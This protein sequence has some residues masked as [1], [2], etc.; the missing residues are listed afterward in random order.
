MAEAAKVRL[1]RCPKCENLLQELPDFSLYQCGGCGAVLKATQKGILEDGLTEISDTVKARGVSEEDRTFKVSEV[2]MESDDNNIEGR[3][4]EKAR[5]EG[6]V[7]NGSSTSRAESTEA[8]R[9]DSDTTRR[10]KERIRKLESFDN[11][12]ASY[13][14]GPSRNRNQ[15]SNL[16]V[17]GPEYVK[18]IRPPPMMDPLRSKP[19]L[20]QKWGMKMNEPTFGPVRGVPAQMRFDDYRYYDE[21]QSSYETS[22]YY[23]PGEKASRYRGHNMDGISQTDNID[24]GR[25][26]LI[27]RLDELKDQI[28]RSCDISDKSKERIISPDPYG[29]RQ[30]PDDVGPTYFA[31]PHVYIPYTD[32][33]IPHGPDP[34]PMRRHPPEF[35][36][37][38]NNNNNNAYKPEIPRR[39]P[40]GPQPQYAQHHPYHEPFPGHYGADVNHH[41]LFTL[42]RHENFF[43]QPAC[44]C[45]YCCDKNWH[46]PLPKP[47]NPS[48]GLHNR[49]FGPQKSLSLNSN[50][51]D[52]EI[53]G[54][55]H[56]RPRKLVVAHR[57][58]RVSHP[59]A[60]GAPFV[61]CS[62]CYEILKLPKKC[63]MSGESQQKLK[64]GACSSIIMFEL[65]NKGFIAS[66]SAHVVDQVPSE[67]DEGSSGT[68]DENMR[69]WNDGLN[70]A[71]LNNFSND[72]EDFVHKKS[73]SDILSSASNISEDE[74]SPKN[75]L[76]GPNEVKPFP[77][78]NL[79]PENI[80][81]SCFDKGNKS[82]RPEQERAS[83]DR[84]TSSQ[85]R[86]VKDA[87]EMD[88]SLNEFSNSCAS[89]DSVEVSKEA[90]K[91]KSS[92][93]GSGESFF[94]GLI[95]RSFI[96]DL[97]KS[98]PG[99]VE[100]GGGS[101]VFINGHFIPD[102]VVK[103]AEKSAGPIKPGDYWYDKRAGFWGVMG[104]PCLGIIM[105]NIEEFNYP[106]PEK[107]AAGNTGVCVNGRELHQKD[108]D[109]L[110]SRGLPIT[111]HRSY[112]VEITGKVIDEQTGQELDGLGKLAPT[113][114]RAKHGFGMKTPRFIAQLNK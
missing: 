112:L 102:R 81:V 18:D 49:R 67:I 70:S 109:L 76:P 89:Q 62:N 73:N 61:A 43:H 50:D 35:T 54:L 20:D 105:P 100:V 107:C 106:L 57:S 47:V 19:V 59:I 22:S 16:Y 75:E 110:A 65:G 29:R 10:G 14:Q 92:N 58:G 87:T 17:D 108:L 84:T 21:G 69:Y 32:R 77:N 48:P 36:H 51:L 103:K 25:A 114:E 42:H 98:N 40:S 11:E 38:S 111:K 64:C 37:Y 33:Y 41:D 68:L 82:Q 85:Q 78:S 79:S 95:K 26:E 8:A 6:I 94:A 63:V 7:S 66:S 88:V 44:S 90:N 34:Y 46:T 24:N 9:A 97:K 28:S 91:T 3:V 101:Q 39:P 113:V 99:A 4:L 52:S 12:Y 27:R 83:L 104:H 31:D 72:Y 45:A 86:S 2:K 53:D 93:K 96:K 15:H 5:N 1:V 74:Q 13:H 30:A 80:A 56:H 55:N 60:G 71:N 23:E